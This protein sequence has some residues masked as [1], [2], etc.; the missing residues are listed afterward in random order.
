MDYWWKR[1]KS[2][3]TIKLQFLSVGQINQIL[4]ITFNRQ[5]V[6]FF[7]LFLT[8]SLA[9]LCIYIIITSVII[10]QATGNYHL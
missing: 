8:I 6:V 10:V 4:N 5:I 2:F 1:K 9:N 3:D 7:D